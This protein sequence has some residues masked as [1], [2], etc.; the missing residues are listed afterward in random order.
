MTDSKRP[1]WSR[2]TRA[3][4][5]WIRAGRRQTFIFHTGRTTVPARFRQ[6]LGMTWVGWLNF[7]VLQWLGLRIEWTPTTE[8]RIRIVRVRWAWP[9]TLWYWSWRREVVV[10]VLVSMVFWASV[11]M[12]LVWML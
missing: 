9:L 4:R 6:L 11:A 3:L 5:R 1:D 10:P 8:G 12:M 2:A 7:C